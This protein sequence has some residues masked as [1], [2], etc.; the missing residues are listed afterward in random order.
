MKYHLKPSRI[1]VIVILAQ[2]VIPA[3]AGIQFVK[4]SLA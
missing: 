1:Q 4:L 3:K 2:A